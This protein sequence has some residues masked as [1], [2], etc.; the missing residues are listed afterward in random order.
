MSKGR[1]RPKVY[2]AD[3]YYSEDE[4]VKTRGAMDDGILRNKEGH[5]IYSR[6]DIREQYCINRKELGVFEDGYFQETRL[7]GCLSTSHI[8]D[9]SPCNKSNSF[10]SCVQ[11]RKSSLEDINRK[12]LEAKSDK[13]RIE[14]EDD[15]DGG[16][17]R[18][19]KPRTCV[20]SD[21]RNTWTQAL[22]DDTSRVY[23]SGHSSTCRFVSQKMPLQVS[24]SQPTAESAFVK[25]IPQQPYR[26]CL[27]HLDASRDMPPLG[28]TCRSFDELNGKGR[29]VDWYISGGKAMDSRDLWD[30][31]GTA[32]HVSFDSNFIVR[33]NT[34]GGGLECNA[35][36]QQQS[37]VE[38][39]AE[40]LMRRRAISP[41]TMMSSRRNHSQERLIKAVVRQAER[42]ISSV[43]SLDLAALQST[44]SVYTSV[45]QHLHPTS[46]HTSPSYI[47]SYRFIRRAI[48]RTQATQTETDNYLGKQNRLIP[49]YL[50]LSPRASHQKRGARQ[51]RY[52]GHSYYHHHQRRLE[53]TAE[54]SQ[55]AE[56][57]KVLYSDES[58][59][60]IMEIHVKEHKPRKAY[61]MSAKA[62]KEKICDA[63]KTVIKSRSRS[64]IKQKSAAENDSLVVFHSLGSDSITKLEEMKYKSS[65]EKSHSVDELEKFEPD[66]LNDESILLR[67]HSL[68]EDFSS[69]RGFGIIHPPLAFSENAEEFRREKN[70]LVEESPAKSST[71]SSKAIYSGLTDGDQH[72]ITEIDELDSSLRSHESPTLVSELSSTELTHHSN[73]LK[74]RLTCLEKESRHYLGGEA[75]KVTRRPLIVGP[76]QIPASFKNVKGAFFEMTSPE[77]ETSSHFTEALS[78]K[79]EKTTSSSERNDIVEEKQSGSGSS[80]YATATDQSPRGENEKDKPDEGQTSFETASSAAASQ[81]SSPS[82]SGKRKSSSSGAE[83]QLMSPDHITE[84]KNIKPVCLLSPR[85]HHG[86]ARSPKKQN[87][88]LF[89]EEPRSESSEDSS[90]AKRERTGSP[91]SESVGSKSVE[92]LE[93]FD[94]EGI[95]DSTP[96]HELC[97]SDPST[98]FEPTTVIESRLHK[99]FAAEEEKGEK[100]DEEIG[101]QEKAQAEK[102]LEEISTKEEEEKAAPTSSMVEADSESGEAE[103]VESDDLDAYGSEERE[104]ILTGAAVFCRRTLSGELSTVSEVSEEIS[105]HKS[106]L[107]GSAS[108]VEKPENNEQAEP[109][110]QETHKKSIDNG[111]RSSSRST[112]SGS[113]VIDCHSEIHSLSDEVKQHRSNVKKTESLPCLPTE[114][115]SPK[116]QEIKSGTSESVSPSV[117][118]QE[119]TTS[120]KVSE[121]KIKEDV[122]VGQVDTAGES[123][124]ATEKDVARSEFSLEQQSSQEIDEESLSM[125]AYCV[126]YGQQEHS[127]LAD[128][129]DTSS[130]TTPT[131]QQWRW[132]QPE[133]K[134]RTPHI[135]KLDVVSEQ[136]PELQ[137]IAEA[138]GETKAKVS[139]SQSES[140]PKADVCQYHEKSST[141]KSPVQSDSKD[142]QCTHKFTCSHCGETV[143]ENV[144]TSVKK[145]KEI[146]SSAKPSIAH[147]KTIAIED[148]LSGKQDDEQDI[149]VHAESYRYASWYYIG[150]KDELIVWGQRLEPEISASSEKKEETEESEITDL[151]RIFRKQFDAITHRMIH[152]KASIEMYKKILENNFMVEKVVT[153]HRSKGEF[154]FRIHGSRPV[155]VSA[156][157][158][159][160]RHANFNELSMVLS[161]GTPAE[162]CGLEIGDIVVSVNEINVLEASHSDVVRLAH[163]GSEFLKL[164][165]VPTCHILRENR[166]YGEEHATIISGYLEKKCTN[167]S[168]DSRDVFWRKRWFV[169]KTDYYLQWYKTANE[170]E[171]LGVFS[172]QSC[173]AALVPAKSCE[174]S[175]VFKISKYS[176]SPQYLAASDEQG[177]LKWVNA[178]NEASNKLSQS[179]PFMERTL[180][181]IHVNPT[182]IPN[183]DCYGFLEK[184]N[185]RRKIWTQRYFVLKDACLYFHPDKNSTTAFGIFYL[186]GYKVQSCTMIAMKNTFEAIP[187]ES[188]FRHLWLKAESELDKK[189]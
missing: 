165:L 4:M 12:S 151:E 60:E 72:S 154:G 77:S 166:E 51:T 175:N 66:E 17:K 79:S 119:E 52:S 16:F 125:G 150:K 173:C 169:L 43:R 45:S 163:S 107:S 140:S 22:R 114:E 24:Y 55:S 117:A 74:K 136:S 2:L 112:T 156:I 70:Q 180:R 20:I 109:I 101:E 148:I 177:A 130:T 184:F 27:L 155:V 124:Q 10:L 144:A 139:D 143:Y 49:A 188:R 108:P 96:I 105:N 73:G 100:E 87:R 95:G 102:I 44:S 30:E 59:D 19:F 99:D 120:E 129:E 15:S 186:H 171:L 5:P 133:V 118:R 138:A 9:K 134:I 29:P 82:S 182:Q 89:P 40:N 110:K 62:S 64:R 98:A 146:E 113:F 122:V 131:N 121:G 181:Y 68:A 153:V 42:S 71:E 67:R 176:E 8:P 11:K 84:T 115:I 32:K 178:L 90:T 160:W 152:R 25:S 106:D 13:E 127:I 164:E 6:E 33:S 116:E 91:G 78:S 162:T 65:F 83:E 58:D 189:R 187:P 170:T 92:Q 28:T 132:K 172:L 111:S 69:E 31:Y 103:P 158:K 94:S 123:S 80:V 88:F 142:V 7:F 23:T 50:T 38:S 135:R 3:Q 159:G 149:G 168:T 157:E 174:M 179:D 147:K 97:S 21:Y 86:Y 161:K 34:I 26:P 57:G 53:V 35:Q 41:P 37:E 183:A 128:S 61:R 48:M 85:P 1:V 18:R 76:P 185:Q 126:T 75:T 81:F 56:K 36:L 137:N 63:E 54:D 47:P 167:I 39:D 46:F 93:E 14:D 145:S 104:F 141:V